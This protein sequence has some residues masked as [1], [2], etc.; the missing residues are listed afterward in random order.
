[1]FESSILLKKIYIYDKTVSEL[2]INELPGIRAY[3]QSIELEQSSPT[4]EP[5]H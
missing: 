3:L 5:K 2:S 4:E 1:M